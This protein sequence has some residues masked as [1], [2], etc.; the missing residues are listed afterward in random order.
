MYIN[1]VLIQKSIYLFLEFEKKSNWLICNKMKQVF[2][3]CEINRCKLVCF[4]FFILWVCEFVQFLC[5]FPAKTTCL[6]FH[7]KRVNKLFPVFLQK[8]Q[9]VV[10]IFP[11]KFSQEAVLNTNL[12]SQ[13]C[14]QSHHWVKLEQDHL[15]TLTF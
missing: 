10:Q 14:V 6:K 4:G 12:S 8:V 7:T 9:L 5:L 15:M 2:S 3:I 11:P 1:F 13:E